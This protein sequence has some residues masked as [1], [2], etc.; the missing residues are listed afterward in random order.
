MRPNKPWT[1]IEITNYLH[2]KNASYK[3]LSKYYQTQHDKLKWECL[4]CK[5][6]FN[7]SWKAM[8]QTVKGEIQGGCPTCNKRV[9]YTIADVKA[10]LKADKRP[11]ISLESTYSN[12][13]APMKWQCTAKKCGH[14]WTNNWK[15]VNGV[16]GFT[17]Q[18]CQKCYEN[19]TQYS[20]EELKAKHI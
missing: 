6:L 10:K 7:R 4:T 17:P 16:A 18:G 8:Q 13:K 12:N 5:T 15:A 11:I 1:F 2:N 3:L 20:I 14:I 9:T 19:N